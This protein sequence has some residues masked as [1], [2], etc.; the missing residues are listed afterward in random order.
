LIGLLRNISIA[1]R[2][3]LTSLIVATSLVVLSVLALISNKSN[4]IDDR[5]SKIQH[6]VE[7]TSGTLE[8]FHQ[9]EQKGELTREQ[10]QQ[11]A[12][13][14]IKQQ[15]YD[16]DNYFWINDSAPIM[17]MHPTKPA[18]DGQSLGDFKDPNGV[19]L[20]NEM[21]AI[22]KK[23]QSGFVAYHWPKP[24]F[25]NPVAK[26]SFVK[27]FQ[28]WGWIVGS[29]I[30][31][32]DVDTA[33][34]SDVMSFAM[35]NV[36]IV[37]FISGLLFLIA[38]SILQPLSDT[39]TMMQQ[40][41]VGDGDLSRRLNTD[42]RDDI[43]ELASYF[44]QFI[45]NL[46][47]MVGSIRLG[48]ERNLKSGNLLPEV[49]DEI[50][51]SS[52][53][54]ND[55]MQ[56]IASSIEQML[57]SSREIALITADA[58]TDAGEVDTQAKNGERIVSETVSAIETLAKDLA[59]GQE[60]TTT[61][62]KGST[63]IGSVLDVIRGI[64]DQTNLLALNAA[65]EAARAGEQGRGFAVV[66]DEVRTL[67]SRTQVSTNEIQQMIEQLQAGATQAVE[68]ME[69]CKSQ[70]D[71]LVGT[72][73]QANESLSSILDMTSRISD[74]NHQ[75]ATAAEEQNVTLAE[76][77]QWCNRASA[78]STSVSQEVEKTVETADVIT[79]VAR[80]LE[81]TVSGFKT[82]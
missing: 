24:G 73:M 62:Q 14:A 81:D 48:V 76:V 43:A 69:A 38:Q 70:S 45:D 36:V 50:R 9:K 5:Q 59:Q 77:S 12:K 22:V 55:Q 40:I 20:F 35:I 28:P 27:G 72:S 82:R 33:F 44:N 47:N 58:S 79:D 75:I 71:D 32:D 51:R 68:A 57:A 74:K 67:A 2:L 42:G 29:G 21:V 8:Y 4:M 1:K 46:A 25:D 52:A 63:S 31:L 37:I 61:L 49:V 13:D 18:L 10:A 30:Y 15:R 11:Q 17:I 78:L 41:A 34:K 23:Q 26:I 54:Q 66:A 65:I 6:L 56:L 7:S 3:L 16:G 53:E 39:N 80:G 19:Y 64:A 60:I